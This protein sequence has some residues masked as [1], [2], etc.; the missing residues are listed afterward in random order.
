MCYRYKIGSG[1]PI[2]ILFFTLYALCVVSA[3]H[4]V[5]ATA[6]NSPNN[7]TCC[8]L[9]CCCFINISFESAHIHLIKFIRDHSSFL[10]LNC[11]VP[12]AEFGHTKQGALDHNTHNV[13]NV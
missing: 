9:L 5:S 11:V 1:N 12:T 13:W 4:V 3:T 10:N 8:C 2:K 6:T 7:F